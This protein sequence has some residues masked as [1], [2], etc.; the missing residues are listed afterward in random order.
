M[1][2]HSLLLTS[3]KILIVLLP[4]DVIN[5]DTFLQF[6]LILNCNFIF[7]GPYT[8]FVNITILS[9]NFLRFL[10]FQSLVNVYTCHCHSQFLHSVAL[11]GRA[12]THTHTHTHT[13]PHTHRSSGQSHNFN[14][15]FDLNDIMFYQSRAICVNLFIDI[16]PEWIGEIEICQLFNVETTWL[17]SQTDVTICFST[18]LRPWTLFG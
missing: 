3:S 8:F 9:F 17:S 12:H 6:E 7:G 16:V 5:A 13:H 10:E 1:Q 14:K 4:L 2:F 15:H 11:K 18:T